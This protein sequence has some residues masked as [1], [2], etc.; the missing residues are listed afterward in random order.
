MK[1]LLVLTYGGHTRLKTLGSEGDTL[2]SFLLSQKEI[3]Q[4]LASSFL[5]HLSAQTP[6]SAWVSPVAPITQLF[7][8]DLSW[9]AL[10][11]EEVLVFS[12]SSVSTILCCHKNVHCPSLHVTSGFVPVWQSFMR[13]EDYKPHALNQSLISKVCLSCYF[14]SLPSI[15]SKTYSLSL[16]AIALASLF[17]LQ[18][19]CIF[20]MM[21]LGYCA[22]KKWLNHEYSFFFFLNGIKGII[23]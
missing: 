17:F 9:N 6:A 23:I 20:S 15:R 18:N 8:S 4:P 12:R 2:V 5:E 3:R 22:F 1:K 7:S 10:S 13:A 11:S 21:L 14:S 16:Y 19:A